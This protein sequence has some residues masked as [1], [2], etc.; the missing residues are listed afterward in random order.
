LIEHLYLFFIS[1]LS[2]LFSAFS[3]GGAG[4]IQLPAILMLYNYPFVVSLASH[5]IATVALGVG[6]SI[7]FFSNIKINKQFFLT[8]L[9]IGL[10]A[11]IIGAYFI[12]GV[13]DTQARL[14][15]GFFIITIAIYSFSQKTIGLNEKKMPGSILKKTIGFT[16]IFLVGLLNGSLSAGTGLLF[17]ISLVTIFGMTYKMAIAYTLIIVGFFYN[18][19]GAI[20]LATYASIS[21]EI[22]PSLIIGSLLGGYIGAHLSISKDNKTIKNFYQIVTLLVG[23]KLIY[24]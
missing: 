17:T 19:V 11:V 21:W 15:L 13:Q 5:K 24:S 16:L 3:G 23:L 12:N 2:N 10:P 14:A 6:A 1:F 4:V 9:F 22:L 7:K 18:L 8:S 20:T